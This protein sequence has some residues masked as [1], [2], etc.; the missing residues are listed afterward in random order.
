MKKKQLWAVIIAA[1]LVLTIGAGPLHAKKKIKIAKIG[2]AGDMTGPLSMYGLPLVHASEFA[3]EYINEVLYPD[4]L[5]I[6]GERYHFKII[7]EDHGGKIEEAPVVGQRLLDEGV[8]AFHVVLGTFY[9][10]IY[11]KMAE[12]GIPMITHS[13]F[14]TEKVED[15]W[16]FRYRNTPSQVMPGT[17]SYV[18]NQFKVKRPSVYSETGAMGTPGGQQWVDALVKAGIG[19]DQIDW[20]QYKYPM[21]EAQFL[22]YL[23]KSMQ[24]GAD[25]I[26]QGATGEGSGTAQACATYL[27][28]KDLGYDGY[29][30]S[31]TGMTD[32]QARKILGRNYGTY[33]KKVYQGEGVDAYTNP[34]PK[35]RKWGR[36]YFAKYK[37]YPIDLVPWGWDVVMVFVSAAYNAGTVTDGEKFRQALADLPFDFLLK[38]E[39][40]TPM[41]PQRGNKLWDEKGQALM[42]V[43]VC[44]WTE[45]GIKLPKAFMV[46]DE[47]SWD[48]KSVKYPDDALVNYLIKEWRERQ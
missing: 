18:V 41:W 40:K 3:V 14:K 20:Q 25:V 42:E 26:V 21:S 38:S 17:A 45:E 16:I 33:L 32:V 47:D 7:K 39:L 13:P 10:P 4:G 11:G 29:F 37:E 2:F 5:E 46:V 1:T 35:I 6:G 9:E 43:M 28:A 27:Q 8:F 19:R 24:W 15:P 34:D 12:M 23:T 36:D 48:I 44:G 30:C 22:P 31:Y